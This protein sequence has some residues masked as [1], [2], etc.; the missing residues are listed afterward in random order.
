MLN[1]YYV[2]GFIVSVRL[3]FIFMTSFHSYISVKCRYHDAHSQGGGSE[4]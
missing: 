1:A 2:L 4:T 3:F